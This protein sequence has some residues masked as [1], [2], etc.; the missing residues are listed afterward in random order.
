MTD[1]SPR[2]RPPGRAAVA[3]QR[4]MRDAG[5]TSMIDGFIGEMTASHLV[6]ERIM[7]L[8]DDDQ[9]AEIA[10]LLRT[11]WDFQEQAGQPLYPDAA[12]RERWAQ[13]SRATERGDSSPSGG[14]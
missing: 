13:S 7:R 8:P 10:A 6:A 1:R 4:I 12:T 11:L 5:L 14:E 2:T 3:L 9:R